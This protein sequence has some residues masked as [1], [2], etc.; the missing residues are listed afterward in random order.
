MDERL[1]KCEGALTLNESISTDD[2]RS[3]IQRL[4]HWAD[5]RPITESAV[6]L[7]ILLKSVSALIKILAKLDSLHFIN[8]YESTVKYRRS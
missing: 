2:A 3:I 1:L 7:D 8:V 5:V 4:F 6:K